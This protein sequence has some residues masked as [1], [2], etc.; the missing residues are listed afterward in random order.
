[1]AGQTFYFSDGPYLQVMHGLHSALSGNEAFVKFIG[2]SRT[3]KSGVCEKLTQ[4]MRHKDY[5]VIYFDY[6][7]ES[8]DMLRNRLAKELDIVD[9][10]NFLRQLE[11]ALAADSEKPLILIF[12]DAHLMSD[13]SLIEIY[14]LASVQVQQR[15]MINLVLCGEPEL[16]RRLNS[17][18]EFTALLHHVSH[19][20]LLEPMDAETCSHFVAAFLIKIEL[21]GLQLEPAAMNQFYKS[22]RGFP[23][24]AYSLCQ[25]LL[26]IRQHSTELSPITREQLQRAIR[27]ADSELPVSSG[28][29]REVSRRL[30]VWPIAAVI[31]IAS[32]ALLAR[33]LSP[34]ESDP[35]SGEALSDAVNASTE[36]ATPSPFAV[37][38]ETDIETIED[39]A[40][41]A[42]PEDIDQPPAIEDPLV[43]ST[44]RAEQLEE[45]IPVSD[46]SLALV[47]AQQRGIPE[48]V[49]AEPEFEAMIAAANAPGVG[50]QPLLSV[51]DEAA[52][53]ATTGQLP[54]VTL[55]RP[56]LALD[57]EE[58]SEPIAPSQPTP[59]E[60]ETEAE[61]EVE[62]IAVPVESSA[63]A[64]A[65]VA[66]AAQQ[67]VQSWLD[68]WQGQDL[69]R[70]FDSYDTDFEPRYHRSK[71]AW[72]SNR[73]RVI[74][75][76]SRI[77]LELSDFEV[78]SED[79]ETVEVHF[80]LAYRS[81]SYRDDTRKKLILRKL[82]ATGQSE[83]RLVILEEINLEV[84]V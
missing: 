15:R 27:G 73:E 64:I 63:P 3:G 62:T 2:Q 25:L 1:M 79:S 47:T 70:Y 4:F 80:W 33:E 59:V 37:N 53:D 77:S 69:E 26:S 38:E 12:D 23:G 18:K 46:S 22:C 17:K 44:P 8:P 83:A 11:D 41:A 16:E 57:D 39:N 24:P 28:H 50:G 54:T 52:V 81:P 10:F 21:P 19:N 14:R 35:A 76:A 48:D 74:G 55:T 36:P 29:Y 7:V 42:E 72:R 30:I 43:Q 75:N 31:V 13:I 40:V 56:M 34:P 82:P 66:E 60:L 20:F 32:L 71:A 78:V 84:R 67:R 61:T 51:I 6:A 65:T 5:R 9:S 49:I 58:I 45:Q 68:A